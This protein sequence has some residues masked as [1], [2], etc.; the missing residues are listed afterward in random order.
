MVSLGTCGQHHVTGFFFPMRKMLGFITQLH[1]GEDY[2]DKTL[3]GPLAWLCRESVTTALESTNPFLLDFYFFHAA[4]QLCHKAQHGAAHLQCCTWPLLR[5][6]AC[7]PPCGLHCSSSSS[8]SPGH[9]PG[10]QCLSC[11]E[12]PKT[13]LSTQGVASPELST[14]G[15]SPPCSCWLHC[16]WYKPGCHRLPWP[17]ALSTCSRW[18]ERGTRPQGP[19]LPHCPP[20]ALMVSNVS[21]SLCW[22]NGR[23]GGSSGS[24][25]FSLPPGQSVRRWHSHQHKCCRKEHCPSL[26]IWCSAHQQHSLLNTHLF[27][28]IFSG[29]LEALQL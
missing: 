3:S 9:A 2:S 17:P 10:P 22:T 4:W 28:D 15:P 26:S 25:H 7:T 19:F 13:E 12:G 21:W 27:S 16:C 8:R 11:S 18:A 23:F 6:A 24:Q 1:G 29:V 20:A 5:F 14:G